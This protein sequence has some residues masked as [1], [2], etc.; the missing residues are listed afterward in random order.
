MEF[1][2]ERLYFEYVKTIELP[3]SDLTNIMIP[4]DNSGIV[5]YTK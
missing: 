5:I 2:E 4:H 3:M 1:F